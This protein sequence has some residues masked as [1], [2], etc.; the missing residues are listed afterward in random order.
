MKPDEKRSDPTDFQERPRQGHRR[1]NMKTR[2]GKGKALSALG[3]CILATA[4]YLGKAPT[5]S[6]GAY[7][8]Q[9][10]SAVSARPVC[11]SVGT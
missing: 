7:I 6:A 9:G 3:V 2:P 4:V 5:E 8:V 1:A 11:S 10:T